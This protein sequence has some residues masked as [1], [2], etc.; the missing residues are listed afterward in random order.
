MTGGERK[1]AEAE[2]RLAAEH[3]EQ[4]MRRR[5]F[6]GRTAALAGA[7]GLASVLPAEAL[8]REAAKKQVQRA[9]PDRRNLPLDHVIVL[10]MENRS[11]DHYFG[12]HPDADARN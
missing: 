5:E 7:A 2:E 4:Q 12:W 6:L 8:V 9:L 3:P 11:F 10:M 1:R